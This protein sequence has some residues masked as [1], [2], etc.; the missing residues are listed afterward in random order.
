M[1]STRIR[2]LALCV[3]RRENSIF[4]SEGYDPR[5]SETFYR[6]IGGGIEFGELGREA[7]AREIQE[8]IGADITNVR[9]LGTLE[10]IFT[11]N[12]NP[13]HELVLLYQAEF[14]DSSFYQDAER[15]I[16]EGGQVVSTAVWKPI[17]LFLKNECLI[18][19]DGILEVLRRAWNLR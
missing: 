11:Y 2:P 6:P 9:L 8:E 5:K 16:I 4:L 18:Y 17:E 15:Q 12:G 14:V 19:P 10:N 1:S 3:F 13:G 7:V